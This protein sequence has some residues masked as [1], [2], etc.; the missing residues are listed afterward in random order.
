MLDKDRRKKLLEIRNYSEEQFDKLIIYL[1]SGGLVLTV[2]FVNDLIEIDQSNCISLLITTWISF[3]LSLIINLFSHRT[4]L[5]STDL[6]LKEEDSKSEF[7]DEVTN[8][9]N[10]TGLIFFIIGVLSFIIYFLINL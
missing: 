5:R 7:W 9:L 3:T 4:S 2:G 8:F 6:E 10:W 1:S